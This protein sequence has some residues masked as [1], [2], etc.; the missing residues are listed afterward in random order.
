MGEFPG[1]D[2][3]P[4]IGIVP[5]HFLEDRAILLHER[6]SH[7]VI[8]AG[9]APL[10][11]PL[12]DDPKTYKTLLPLFDGFLMPGGQDINPALYGEKP[13]SGNDRYTPERDALEM[14]LLDYAYVHDAPVLA[15]CRG[16]QMMNVFFGG[17]LHQDLNALHGQPA[18]DR[19]IPWG[20]DPAKPA[21]DAS[22]STWAAETGREYIEHWRAD[23]YN[24]RVHMVDVRPAS[25]LAGIVGCAPLATNSIHHQGVKQLGSGLVADAVGPDGLVEAIEVPD[26]TFMLGVQWHPEFILNDPSMSNFFT[27]LV[28]QAR[29]YRRRKTA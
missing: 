5:R 6:Y 25:R 16:M 17:T 23:R 8:A 11:L 4:L 26:R 9:G 13:K 18:A 22:P 20:L 24:Q 28:N 15:I 27:M 29:V 3:A 21:E 19:R 1:A 10:V 12:S 14:R 7:A 2:E